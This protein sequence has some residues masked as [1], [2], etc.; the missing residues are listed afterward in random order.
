M[1][2]KAKTF[3]NV[4]VYRAAYWQ[5]LF[6]ESVSCCFPVFSAEII[7]ESLSEKESDLS[8]D[9]WCLNYITLVHK[10]NT[11]AWTKFIGKKNSKG[12]EKMTFAHNFRL[13]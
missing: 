6:I 1:D 7:L 10:N 5:V 8:N 12:K 4:R 9:S 11:D 13:G 3:D 2:W